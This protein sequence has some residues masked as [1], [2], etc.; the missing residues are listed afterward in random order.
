MRWIIGGSSG[1]G[2]A[3]AD[4]FS[5]NDNGII[6]L[7][8]DARDCDVRD[9]EAVRNRLMRAVQA[10]EDSGGPLKTIVYSA[11]VNELAFLGT[12]GSDGLVDAAD[13][14]DVNLMGFIRLLDAVM[15]PDVFPS[16]WRNGLT[17]IAVSSDASER[18]MRTSAAYC[19]SKA[20][21]NMAIKSAARELASHGI[22][23][24]GIAPG[25]TE[26]TGMTDYIDTT[27]PALRGWSIQQTIDYERQQ[28]VTPGRVTPGELAGVI[29]A[30]ANGPRHW[31][32]DIVT[33]NGGR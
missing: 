5:R 17:I 33:V 3:T 15:A 30:I 7:V 4:I 10:S 16:H 18:P 26:G 1:I 20:G 19:A 21:L 12:M 25:M 11:G 31:T 24:M 6:P 14:I 29:L 28:E 32:G 13:V 23:V 22:R 9:S 27:V 2:S 8:S